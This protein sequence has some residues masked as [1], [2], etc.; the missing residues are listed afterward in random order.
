[1]KHRSIHI[2]VFVV[3]LVLTG[4]VTGSR[5]GPSESTYQTRREEIPEV[6][7]APL[8]TPQSNRFADAAAR[9]ATLRN[10]LTWTF[11]GKQQRGWYL[12]DSL[13]TKT[14]DTSSD[15]TT[16]DFAA[17]VAAWQKRR[18]LAAN[19]VLDEK[20]LMAIVSHWQSNRLKSRT[21]ADPSE[22]MI[23]PPADFYD[24]GRAAEL[25]QVERNTYA[26]YKEMI[27]AAMADRSLNLKSTDRF[28][29]IISSYRSQ[30]HQDRLREQSPNS[31]RAGLAVN[32]PH[33]TGRA[34]DIYVGGS[35]VDT[36]DANRAIQVNTRAYQWLVRNAERFGFRPYFYEPWHWEY[37]K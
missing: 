4:G 32:S 8:I 18:G 20:P 30:E 36:A 10:D 26:A 17:A 29:K 28:L 14:L 35:P 25:R 22:L 6:E 27:A 9:N 19:G 2:A 5:S 24:T 1:M 3:L 15:A 33:F 16:T 11:G 37:V 34:L 12:Y 21:P 31:G 13:L 23:A 7:A